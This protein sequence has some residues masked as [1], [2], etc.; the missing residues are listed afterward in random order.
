MTHSFSRR[1]FLIQAGG[2]GLALAGTVGGLPRWASAQTTTQD[3]LQTPEL[4]SAMAIVQDLYSG[5]TLFER[6]ADRRAPI[7]SI[8]KLMTALVVMDAAQPLDQIL[9]VSDADIDR[10]KGTGSRLSVGTRLSRREML[11][12]SLMSS[13]NRAANALGRYYPGGLTRMVQA[14]NAKAQLL[15][16]H[17][18]RFVEPTGLSPQNASTPRELVRLLAACAE[19]PLMTEMSTHEGLTVRVGGS[20][21]AFRNSN[22]LVR[23]G[24]WPMYVSKTGFIREAGRCVAMVSEIG[25]RQVAMVLLRAPSSTLRANDARVLH[26]YVSSRA[27]ASTLTAQF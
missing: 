4:R 6:S 10:L 26:D 3:L 13:E 7:A 25:G 12:L 27:Q 24:E 14:M 23:E 16:M 11:H 20:M 21:L 17:E 18:S 8:T 15:G 2:F 19:Y 9:T 5:E 22:V 1:R